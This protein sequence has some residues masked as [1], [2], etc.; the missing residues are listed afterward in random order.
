[1]GNNMGNYVCENEKSQTVSDITFCGALWPDVSNYASVRVLVSRSEE[2][3]SIWGNQRKQLH[4][5]FT[6]DKSKAYSYK[7]CIFLKGFESI[8]S[9]G[10]IRSRHLF[11]L[12]VLIT[13]PV[14]LTSFSATSRGQYGN[15]RFLFDFLIFAFQ[16]TASIYITLQLPSLVNISLLVIFSLSIFQHM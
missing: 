7:T 9:S 16:R 11:L 4:Y 12:L 14:W 13:K 15:E 8:I 6:S 5:L 1:M 3:Q 10:S 2:K